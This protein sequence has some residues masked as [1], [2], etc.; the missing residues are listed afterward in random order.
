VTW[1]T[2]AGI[3]VELV[4]WS[5]EVIVNQLSSCVLW[6]ALFVAGCGTMVAAS[7]A[8]VKEHS[9]PQKMGYLQ[10]KFE[11][12]FWSSL[13]LRR[14][15]YAPSGGADIGECLYIAEQIKEGDFQSWYDEWTKAAHR[16][17]SFSN[18][19]LS[20]NHTETAR[21]GLFRC[22]N[23]FLASEF[24]LP[25]GP[26]KLAVFEKAR[27]CFVRASRLDPSGWRQIQVPYEGT[28]LPG[29]MYL[30]K[31]ST[32]TK[33]II[34]NT[35]YD[36]T[37]EELY[38]AV[39]FFAQKRNYNVV[40]FEGPGQGLPLRKDNLTFR[41][42]WEKVIQAVV[43]FTISFKEVDQ[44]CLALY[45][46][47]FGGNLVPRAAAYEPRIKALIVNSPINSFLDMMVH[48]G[49]PAK[50]AKENPEQFDQ[51]VLLARERSP[52]LKHTIDEGMWKIG[53]K[54][55]S[56]WVHNLDKYTRKDEPGL[57]KCPTLVVDSELDSMIDRD[58]AKIFY[59]RLTCPKEMVLFTKET[60][61]A[62]HCQMGACLYAN[63][64]IF[65]WLDTVF[66]RPEN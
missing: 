31:S 14:I 51:E 17:L 23:Y 30:S 20:H 63:E 44:N 25:R 6:S 55:P 66:D 46:R 15:G 39:G 2:R 19:A 38:F 64:V 4:D 65:D 54:T 47:S 62:T 10:I 24:F 42:D 26:Q 61:A 18:E 12:P 59:D 28:Y 40:I 32:P 27:D 29:F 1:P 9:E 37:A 58:Q 45:G 36:G 53:G 35:G 57:I 7:A 16:L 48:N 22:C 50:L 11:D 52:K 60:A 21:E 8:P 3:L 33:T 13:L 56:E 41:P 34:L 43:D 49:L 5:V